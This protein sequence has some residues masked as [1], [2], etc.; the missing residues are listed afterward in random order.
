[1]VTGGGSVSGQ[2]TG[3]TGK[4]GIDVSGNWPAERAGLQ[5]SAGA[6][7]GV[8]AVTWRQPIVALRVAASRLPSCR[9]EMPSWRQPLMRQGVKAR[10]PP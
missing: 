8:I 3:P 7:N 1:M 6:E 5:L 4:D 2:A 9:A 10:W